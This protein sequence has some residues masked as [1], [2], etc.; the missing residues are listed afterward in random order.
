MSPASVDAKL[1][2]LIAKLRPGSIEEIGAAPLAAATPNVT[3]AAQQSTVPTLEPEPELD[4]DTDSQGISA[5]AGELEPEPEVAEPML[6]A[7]EEPQAEFDFS[8]LPWEILVTK[9]AHRQL[10][11]LDKRVAGMA[12][13]KIQAIGQGSWGGAHL[14]L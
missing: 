3:A 4:G 7:E 10:A 1:E 8:D 11:R 6:A 13:G 9:E 5:P 12:V 14:P 2:H